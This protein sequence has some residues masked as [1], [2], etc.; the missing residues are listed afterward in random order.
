MNQNQLTVGS[1]YKL[2]KRGNQLLADRMNDLLSDYNIFNQNVKGFYW[3]FQGEDYFEI[4]QKFEDLSF[5]LS[6][7]IDRLANAIVMTGYVPV[8]TF[9]E[10]I[11]FSRHAEIKGIN[12]CEEGVANVVRGI[13]QLLSAT[14]SAAVEAGDAIDIESEKILRQFSVELENELWVFTMLAKY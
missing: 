6:Q 11:K 12:T 8:H 14:R 2:N 1:S 5:K 7:D 10:Y 9:S 4:H 3:N 13:N